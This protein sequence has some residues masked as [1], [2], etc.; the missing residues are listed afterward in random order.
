MA[1]Q[2]ICSACGTV[3]PAKSVTK[4]SLLIEIV[5]WLCFLIPGI[6]YSL[7]RLTTKHKACKACGA[8]TL[9]PLDTPGGRQL[10]NRFAGS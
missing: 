7:W 2:L 6:I 4:G 8:Q 1:K 9:V 3:G 10:Q 5:L